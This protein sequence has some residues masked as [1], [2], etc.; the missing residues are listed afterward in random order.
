VPGFL[1]IGIGVGLATPTLGSAAMAAVP[2]ERGGMA[3]GAVN[4]T[5]QLGFA[6]GIA[7]LG[8]VFTA[9]AQGVLSDHGVPSAAA[10]ARAVAGGQS[11]VL[12]GHVPSGVRAAAQSAVHDSAVA[13]VQSTLV[14][15]GVIGILAG[16][17]VLVLVRP[18]RVA[19]PA[20]EGELAPA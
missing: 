6:F 7:A 16:L 20:R 4:T 3:A 12:L 2:P 10:A 14:V 11:S 5:R 15:A 18:S 1:V 8:S 17:L 13:G 9:R 19:A